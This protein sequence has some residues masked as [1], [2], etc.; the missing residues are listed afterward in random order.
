LL[1][2]RRQALALGALRGLV[3]SPGETWLREA[4]LGLVQHL[5]VAVAEAR[6]ALLFDEVDWAWSYLSHRGIDDLTVARMLDG[7]HRA[8]GELGLGAR[9]ARLYA[10]AILPGACPPPP[11]QRPYVGGA[12]RLGALARHYLDALLRF[13]RAGARRLALGCVAAEVP[14]G[15]VIVGVLE[16][17]QREVGRLWQ[18]NRIGVA[19]ERHCTVSTRAV[20]EQLRSETPAA[21]PNGLR[22]VVTAAPGDPHELGAHMVANALEL[23]GWQVV[24]L[25]AGSPLSAVLEAVRLAQPNVLAVSA[26][27]APHLGSVRALLA[28]AHCGRR[29]SGVRT[30]VGGALFNAHAELWQD[31]G[32]DGYAADSVAAAAVA[33]RLAAC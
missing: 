21:P 27:R 5:A 30:L 11:T 15:E 18:L 4:A 6:P 17:A 2:D 31:V 23:Q 8:V 7:L 10:E 25:G 19:Q 1:D 3:P 16:P 29:T 24:D 20:L 26:A 22:A 13:D 12:N 33:L 28:A 32:A 9:Q 14:P